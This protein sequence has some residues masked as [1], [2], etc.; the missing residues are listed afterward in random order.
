MRRVTWGIKLEA[1]VWPEEG[2]DEGEAILL[3]KRIV[4]HDYETN[5]IALV[6]SYDQQS[7]DACKD[8]LWFIVAPMI[9]E[10]RQKLEQL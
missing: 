1:T 4:L 5:L 7:R 2:D 6:D 9:A 3:G 8:A 10:V